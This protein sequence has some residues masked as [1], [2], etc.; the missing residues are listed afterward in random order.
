[1]IEVL[2][3]QG[4]NSYKYVLAAALLLSGFAAADEAVGD[5]ASVWA[6]V[7]QQ[8]NAVEDGDRKW[9]DELL[10][11]DFSG[12]PKNSPAPRNKASTK[13]WNR[14][15]ESQGKVV[16][17]ELYPLAIIVHGDVAIAHYL[18]TSAFKNKDGEVEMNNGRYSDVLVR[19]DGGWKFLSWHGGSDK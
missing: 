1:M 13:M 8:W 17:H 7:E 16:A 3:M 18:Y 12:W 11:A 4:F 6:V 19:A 10:A 5:Q 2:G 15:N 14:F 9:I